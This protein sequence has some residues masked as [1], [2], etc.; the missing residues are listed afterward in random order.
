MVALFGAFEVYRRRFH[1]ISRTSCGHAGSQFADGCVSPFTAQATLWN[2]PVPD[3]GFTHSGCDEP[4]Q[5]GFSATVLNNLAACLPLEPGAL[6]HG[7]QAFI[8]I[9][10]T[11]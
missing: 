3:A 6:A 10:H 8:T 2:W 11:L 7:L 5:A 4:R 9:N 1:S